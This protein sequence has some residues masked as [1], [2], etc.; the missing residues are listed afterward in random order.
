MPNATACDHSRTQITAEPQITRLHGARTTVDLTIA[1]AANCPHGHGRTLYV[2]D[3]SD[4]P[5]ACRQLAEWA[6]N[7]VANCPGA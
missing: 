7:H 5:E 4:M 6:E 1:L 2:A 3:I